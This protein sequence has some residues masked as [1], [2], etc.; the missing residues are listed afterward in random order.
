MRAL[1]L[2]EYK[3]LDV[4]DVPMRRWASATCSGACAPAASAAATCTATTGRP[5]AA[6]RP[7]SWVTRRRASSSAVGRG[8]ARLGAGARVTFD[9]TVS[10]GSCA[11]LPRGRFQPLRPPSG[12]R[13]C[14]APSSAARAPTPSTCRVPEHIVYSVPDEIPLEQAAWWSRSRW[15]SRRGP[16]SHARAHRGGGGHGH[17]RPARHPGPARGGDGA[18]PGRGRGR[19]ASS[20]WRASWGRTSASTPRRRRARGGAAA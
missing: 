20:R 11:L 4:R 10:C 17:D 5:A 7:W 18:R 8:V 15:P 6:S 16:R 12:P 2:S 1:V 9:S 13:R 3:R 14:R 19:E